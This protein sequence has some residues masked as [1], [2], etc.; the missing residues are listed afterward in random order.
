MSRQRIID[1]DFPEAT[2]SGVIENGC[3]P[4]ADPREWRKAVREGNLQKLAELAATD[5]FLAQVQGMLDKDNPDR[6]KLAE[7]ILNRAAGRPGVG[8]QELEVA[9]G[10]KLSPLDIAR[11]LQFAETVG[12]RLVQGGKS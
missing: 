10:Q 11:R 7:Q 8:R 1:P 9:G 2:P 6:N 12:L 4:S 3:P 5:A